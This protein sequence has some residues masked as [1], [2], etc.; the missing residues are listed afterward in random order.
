MFKSIYMKLFVTYL[1]LFL[2]IIMIISFFMLSIFYKEFT[3]LAEED[4]VNAG[5]KTNALVERY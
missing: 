4:L 5:N 3:L 2:A 1:S